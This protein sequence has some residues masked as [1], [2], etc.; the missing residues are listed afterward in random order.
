[1]SGKRV[2][3]TPKIEAQIRA[4]VD[5]PQ[6]DVSNFAVYESRTLTT[7]ALNASGLFRGGRVSVG[8]LEDMVASLNKQ[9][10]A[11]PLQVM[12]DTDVLPVGKIFHG[13]TKLMENGETEIRSLFY[14][15]PSQDKLIA[16][17]EASVID[18]V[19][20]GFRPEHIYCSECGFD[21]LSEDATFSNIYTATCNEDHTIGQ[22][23]VYGRLVGLK[24]W[25]EVS[26]VGKGAAKNPK[27]LSRAKQSLGQEA[28]DRLAASGK[29]LEA[30]TVSAHYKLEASASA[31]N[32]KGDL[33]MDEKLMAQLTAKIEEVATVK[34]E[35]KQKDEAKAAVDAK[36]TELEAS[37]KAKDAEIAELSK[38]V[39]KA[40][41][42]AKVEE[43]ETNLK[44]AVEKLRPHAVAALV[45]SGKTA[46][47][48][49]EDTSVTAMLEIIE[50]AGLK[51]HQ[52]V[53]A[54]AS[55]K[56]EEE[57]KKLV[58]TAATL[59]AKEA[60]KTPKR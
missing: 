60:F 44:G 17:I 40:A 47:D 35:L 4:G 14:V 43:T 24:S 7:E 36:V 3:I 26:L 57:S 18:E 32:N 45:A 21:Y 27:I 11:I 54:S 25:M 9:G 50:S 56:S 10:G 42:T 39:D 30:S 8:T 38:D 53:A 5:D 37:L 16:D 28:V 13:E 33:E 23:G 59:R 48:L 49:K 1:M 34:A 51:L 55:D 41:L 31:N 2:K 6:A 20:V 46:E 52:V 58:A 15:S 29:P 22:S 19:S 12:H